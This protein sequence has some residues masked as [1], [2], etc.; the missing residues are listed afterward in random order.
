MPSKEVTVLKKGGIQNK[1]AAYLVQ[2]AMRYESEITFEQKFKKINAKSIMGV[3]SLALKEGDKIL[4]SANG[5]D[6]E[7]AIKDISAILESE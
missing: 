4:I 2:R 3:I 5:S 6:A 1:D 7:E